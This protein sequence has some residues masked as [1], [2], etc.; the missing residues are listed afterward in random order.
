MGRVFSWGVVIVGI[1]GAVLW[2]AGVRLPHRHIDDARPVAKAEPLDCDATWVGPRRGD[3]RSPANWSTGRRPGRSSHVCI[4]R[5]TTVEITRGRNLV[6]AVEGGSLDLRGGA[7]LMMGTAVASEVAD[8]RLVDA[9][10]GGPGKLIVTRH[11]FFGPAGK[12]RGAGSV[13]LGPASNSVIDAGIGKRS[14]F[15]GGDDGAGRAIVNSDDAPG[16][17]CNRYSPPWADDCAAR[18]PR[19][20]REVRR[21]WAAFVAAANAGSRSALVARLAPRACGLRSEKRR[22]D[23][24]HVAAGVLKEIAGEGPLSP[25]L[26]LVLVEGDEAVADALHPPDVRFVRDGGEWRVS[27][28]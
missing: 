6:W 4:P 24:R 7:L 23:C 25:T 5:G 14:A 13:T 18:H 1:V 26:K 17:L 12:M 27:L 11:M 8:L 20:D 16:P 2:S 9:T 15:I 19:E 3:W 28:L 10:L 21:A 22:G